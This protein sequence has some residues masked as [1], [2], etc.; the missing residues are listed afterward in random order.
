MHITAR[1]NGRDVTF[2]GNLNELVAHIKRVSN[3]PQELIVIGVDEDGTTKVDICKVN[4]KGKLYSVTKSRGFFYSIVKPNYVNSSWSVG[5]GKRIGHPFRKFGKW[6]QKQVLEVKKETALRQALK[7]QLLLI[8]EDLKEPMF[9]KVVEGKK[10]DVWEIPQD[11]GG[12]FILTTF[13]HK[14]EPIL[15]YYEEIG[16]KHQY[17]I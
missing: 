2:D 8:L 10:Y 4:S 6:T 1:I 12:G 13:N 15:L 9:V 17:C 7:T 14:D 16:G 11:Y 3:D 5:G